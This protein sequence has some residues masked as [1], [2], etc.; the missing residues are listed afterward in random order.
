VARSSG[1]IRGLIS[2]R[3]VWRQARASRYKRG[4]E[5]EGRPPDRPGF[6]SQRLC[7]PRRLG[8]PLPLRSRAWPHA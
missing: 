1:Q 2:R 8:R 7:L 3:P 5:P 4:R 6:H